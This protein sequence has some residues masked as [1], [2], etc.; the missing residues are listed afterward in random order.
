MELL[1]K[2]YGLIDTYLQNSERYGAI[3]NMLKEIE[4]RLVMCPASTKYHGNYPGGL[5]EH[6][7]DCID[8]AFF[9]S[10]YLVF[11]GVKN[12]PSNESILFCAAFHDIGKMGD[13]KID[14]YIP[15]LS[16]WHRKNLGRTYKINPDEQKVLLTHPDGSIY[17]LNHFGIKLSI[18]E[19]QAIKVHDGEYAKEN[20][21]VYPFNDVCLL[22]HIIQLADQLS[23][24]IRTDKMV[25]WS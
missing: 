16:D 2:Y 15:E 11:I 25:K 7:V 19:Y 12:I 20:A 13:D 23:C 6:L 14:Y 1:N 21:D 10:N 5:L 8:A 17:L 18:E 24:T 4:E 3:K 22:T 9:I